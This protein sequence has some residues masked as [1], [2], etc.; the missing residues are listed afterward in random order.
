MSDHLQETVR[1][2]VDLG[3]HRHRSAFTVALRRRPVEGVLGPRDEAGGRGA[4]AP[5][6]EQL[7][8][9]SDRIVT[10]NIGSFKRPDFFAPCDIAASR[11]HGSELLPMQDVTEDAV[12]NAA[13]LVRYRA[14]P[15]RARA[16]PL[17]SGVWKCDMSPI[18]MKFRHN[19][20]DTKIR[21]R[22]LHGS[23]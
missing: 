7:R 20:N 16:A 8:T 12:G 13:L 5:D 18:T 1:V 21:P 19:N 11:A 3:N 6:V 22:R 17:V 10:V 23:I 15:E 9:G 2:V 4:A 14:L